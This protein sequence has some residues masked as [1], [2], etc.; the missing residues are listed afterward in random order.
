MIYW[1]PFLWQQERRNH[2]G[3]SSVLNL[4]KSVRANIFP[5]NPEID[6]A[7]LKGTF[8]FSLNIFTEFI[9]FNNKKNYEEY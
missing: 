4:V 3:Q 1:I 6:D 5:L 8:E 9:E 7:N 2:W